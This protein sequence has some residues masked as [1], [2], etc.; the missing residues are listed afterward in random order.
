MKIWGL[1]AALLIAGPGL[2]QTAPVDIAS[3][4]NNALGAGWEHWKW[5]GADVEL[6]VTLEGSVR[7]P[8][9]VEAQGYKG[10]YL[11]HAAFSTAPF[12]G[13]AMLIQATGGPGQVRIIAI[14]NGQPIPDKAKLVKIAP[15]GWTKVDV[16]LAVLG[17]ENG[18]IDGIWVQNDSGEASPRFYVTDI[19]FH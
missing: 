2:A 7:K 1:A 12:Q 15:G 16:P 8:I 11:H 19:M 5:D 9:R 4:Y 17:A 6:G 14:R 18:M 13:L 3:V 10:L